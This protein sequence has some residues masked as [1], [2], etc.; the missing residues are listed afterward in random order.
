MLTQIKKKI[1]ITNHVDPFIRLQ[2]KL[3]HIVDTIKVVR[4]KRTRFVFS[5]RA[6]AS[7]VWVRLVICS[8]GVSSWPWGR[9]PE[10]IQPPSSGLDYNYKSLVTGLVKKYLLVGSQELNFHKVLVTHI[11]TCIYSSI[12]DLQMM[13]RNVVHFKTYFLK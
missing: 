8:M 1:G 5:D 7:V 9:L 11:F 12:Q 13:G 4:K 3:S 2:L 10:Q 6:R